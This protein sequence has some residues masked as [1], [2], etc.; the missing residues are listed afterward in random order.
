[1]LKGASRVQLSAI[2]SEA[3]WDQSG[4]LDKIGSEV[5]IKCTHE[6]AS[7]PNTT[8]QL[9]RFQDRKEG[10]FLLGPTHEEEIT[11]IV[12]KAVQSYKSL[13]LRLYQISKST[14]LTGSWLTLTFHD[15]TEISR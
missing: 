14:T 6:P 9:F 4:R 1:M 5:R 15:S 8:A 3:L 7:I 2:S 10:R 11:S 12:A 13:P